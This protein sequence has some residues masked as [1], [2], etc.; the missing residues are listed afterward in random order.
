M[1]KEVAR[2][3]RISPQELKGRDRRWETARKRAEAVALLV[4]HHG[5]KVTEVAKSLGRDQANVSLML[6]RFAAR[7]GSPD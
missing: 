2:H 7:T 3:L 5:Y 6:S 1:I 4:Q